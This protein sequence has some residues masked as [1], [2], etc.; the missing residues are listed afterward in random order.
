MPVPLFGTWV[1]IFVLTLDIDSAAIPFSIFAD[2]MSE[3]QNL[4]RFDSI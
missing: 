4:A 3:P 2:A 1:E